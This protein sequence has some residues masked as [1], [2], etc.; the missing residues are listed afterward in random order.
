M[1]SFEHLNVKQLKQIIREYNLITKITVSKKTKFQLVADIKKHLYI[2]DEGLIKF[3][4]Q[5]NNIAIPTKPQPKIKVKKEA[6]EKDFTKEI[7]DMKKTLEDINDKLKK[8]K[9]KKSEQDKLYNDL[10]SKIEKIQKI[11]EKKEEKKEE[12]L[13]ELSNK[14]TQKIFITDYPKIIKALNKLNFRGRLQTNKMLLALQISQN[15]NTKEKIKKLLDE[16]EE[17]KA[18][19]TKEEK[20]NLF[21]YIK[22][23]SDNEHELALAIEDSPPNFA[24]SLIKDV[25]KIYGRKEVNEDNV[26]EYIKRVKEV[27]INPKVN[28]K[29]ESFLK[30][31]LKVLK[32]N[33]KAFEKVK[34][35]YKMKP[36]IDLLDEIEKIENEL[37]GSGKPKDNYGLHAV[38]IKKP[39]DLEEAKKKAQEFIKD[40]K[41]K[42]YRE[43]SSSY[44][45]R[46]IPKQKFIS[47]TFRTKK[48]NKEISLIFGELKPEHSHLSGSGIFDFF[49]KGVEKVKEFFSPRLDG[50]SNTSKKTLE[51]YGN[52]PIKSLTIYRTPIS[53]LIDKALNLIS[54][55]KFGDL[56]KQYGFDKLFH[57]AL[58]ANVGSKNIIIEKNE[59]VNISTEYK[60]SKDTE[61]FTIDMKGQT[62]TVNEMLDKAR[63]NVGDKTFFDYDA[64]KNNCQFFIRYCLEAVGLYS[65]QAKNFLFQ[66]VEGIYKGLPSYVSKIA[67]VA[68]R[69]GAVASKIL[70]RG[71]N[72]MKQ[73]IYKMEG[74]GFIDDIK[75]KFK[76]F[77][78]KK[79]MFDGVEPL[80]NSIIPLFNEG[81]NQ[82]KGEKVINS[83]RLPSEKVMAE[84]ADKSY[85]LGNRDVKDYELIK[86]TKTLSF[87]KKNDTII[88]IFR[89]TNV[90]DF[91]DLIADLSISLNNL[92]KSERY[93]TDYKDISEFQK[94][95]PPNKY[96]YIGVGHS[97]GGA[98]VDEFINNGML[99]EGF[100]FNPAIQKKDYNKNNKH[101]RI[102]LSNDPLYKIMGSYS[103]YH[104][105]RN[106]NLDIGASHSISNFL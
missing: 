89:G 18:E 95:Y 40:K 48:I 59:V 54:F 10:I 27:F 47:K 65:E 85:N 35:R 9:L 69:T 8:S 25:N 7:Q 49:K 93:R 58:V 28:K 2:D 100:S 73:K 21:D 98:L 102:Y 46:N 37:S 19:E 50:Y 94:E 56:K 20:T 34:E 36:Y 75:D 53:S 78:S 15:F 97:L 80:L 74:E 106:K 1:L 105:V 14:L 30:E 11:P 3:I 88:I 77:K 6:K 60:T 55:G 86:Q 83:N 44:R 96:Y 26:K 57:L 39:Y 42:Y 31:R 66:D 87:Y 101:R 16:L 63:K 52:L 76:E 38:I 33:M 91:H 4:E 17:K 22:K 67:K 90:E 51:Q 92:S 99:K 79:S 71:N 104:E 84:M 5:E 70:G 81:L 24:R 82:Q 32:E 29:N 12:S 62:F 64:F 13:D 68:T 72:K 61:T 43:T 103:K 23:V 45:F 41:K